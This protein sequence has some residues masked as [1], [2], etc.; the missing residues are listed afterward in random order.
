[1][2]DLPGHPPP[3]L[4]PLQS[5]LPNHPAAKDLLDQQLISLSSFPSS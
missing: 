3:T 2:K 5:L 4:T 1:M